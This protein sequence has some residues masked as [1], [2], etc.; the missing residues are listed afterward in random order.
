M[1]TKL[2]TEFRSPSPAFIIACLALFVALGGSSYAAV[3]LTKNSVRSAHI[4]NGQVKRAD[5]R[6][7]A[8]NSSKVGN[9]S[10]LAADFAPGQLPAGAKGD[11]GDTGATG[12]TGA[13]GPAGADGGPDAF[14]RV[15]ENAAR[16]LEPNDAG[17]AP[18]NR[19][20][21]QANV[22]PGEGG[23]ATGTTCFDL[24]SRP[25]SA[26][27]VLDNADA[28]ANVDKIVSVAIDRG[29]DLGDCPGTHN[30]ARVRILDTDLTAGGAEQDPGPAN[31]RFF[32]WF[33]L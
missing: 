4:K 15:D 13:Q 19:G 8:V 32:V 6:N 9:S 20:I 30:D 17:Q 14:A 31:A 11:K 33:E 18:Q 10:L 3:I 23:A 2:R 16:T 27:A 25:A 1:L 5:L 26:I 28:A 22:V 24:P 7:N 12:A 29:E 21:V